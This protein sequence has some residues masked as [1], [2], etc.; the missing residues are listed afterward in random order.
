MG[1]RECLFGGALVAAGVAT[2]ALAG[3]VTFID[4]I[5]GAGPSDNEW[6]SQ[7][8]TD[9]AGGAY[10]SGSFDST[11]ADDFTLGR[12]GTVQRIVAVFGDVT[13]SQ[14]ANVTAWNV[15][16]YS[17][18]TAAGSSLTGDV[19]SA[20]LVP[21]ITSI[22]NNGFGGLHAFTVT[23]DVNI[24]LAAGTYWVGVNAEQYFDPGG[25]PA[26]LF[27]PESEVGNGNAFG[28][29]PG[30]SFGND[31]ITQGTKNLQY[32]VIGTVIPMPAPVLMSTAGIGLVAFR[33]RRNELDVSP[34][35]TG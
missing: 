4:Q 33:R 13:N 10:Q 35:P 30:G 20:T 8:F 25:G 22:G 2:P 29:N 6:T 18:T 32:T 28:A 19:F 11:A 24:P 21:T 3:A 14:G 27:L 26:Q 31:Y 16:L 5:T 17:S 12:E 1:V 9:G 23:F 15:N 7:I 34:P